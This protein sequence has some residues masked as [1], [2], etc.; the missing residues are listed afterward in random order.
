MV[1]YPLVTSKDFYKQ[2]GSIY[3]EYKISKTTKTEKELCYPNK[4]KLQKPKDFVAKYISPKTPYNITVK[5]HFPI[6]SSMFIFNPNAAEKL[7]I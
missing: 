7:K 6:C 2:I 4:Y 5:R 1:R 3:K